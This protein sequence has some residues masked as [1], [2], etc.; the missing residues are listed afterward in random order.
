MLEFCREHDAEERFRE[1]VVMDAVMANV[2]RHAGNYGFVVDNATGNVLRMAPLF[3]HSMAC[4]PMMMEG[5]NFDAYVDAIGPKI[6]TDLVRI[7]RELITPAIRTKLIALRDFR[8]T[9]PLRHLPAADDYPIARTR[10]TPS[11]TRRQDGIGRKG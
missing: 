4:L 8:Y 11:T 1:M 10:R 7:A 6:G 3:D 9:D 2:D 5:D